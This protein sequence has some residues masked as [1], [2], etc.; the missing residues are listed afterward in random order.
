MVINHG[1]LETVSAIIV[2][3][4][5][6]FIKDCQLKRYIQPN[7]ILKAATFKVDS[8][9]TG[10]ELENSHNEGECFEKRQFC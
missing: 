4:K 2:D 6:H 8:T 7:Q 10:I 3:K 5:I 1:H 9:E